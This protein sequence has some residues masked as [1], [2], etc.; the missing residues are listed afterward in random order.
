MLKA[1]LIFGKAIY[2]AATFWEGNE[3]NGSMTDFPVLCQKDDRGVFRIANDRFRLDAD[4]AVICKEYPNAKNNDKAWEL[5]IKDFPPTPSKPVRS[6][7]WIAPD[8]RFFKCPNMGHNTTAEMI[9]VGLLGRKLS[10]LYTF[11]ETR[12]MVIK[13]EDELEALG[14]GRFYDNGLCAIRPRDLVTQK[15]INTLKAALRSA[16]RKSFKRYDKE[17]RAFYEKSRDE[18]VEIVKHQIDMFTEIIS[19]RKKL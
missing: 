6:A 15:Q 10:E 18:W 13:P 14:W 8:G 12:M 7:A 5:Y 9:F 1:Q 19:E 17:S 11:N 16:R 3:K 4:R 2:V